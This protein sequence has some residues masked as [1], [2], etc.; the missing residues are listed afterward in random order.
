MAQ[1]KN[2]FEVDHKGMRELHSGRE[3]WQLIK[4][5]VSNSFD[6]VSATECHVTLTPHTDRTAELVVW[7][8]GKGFADIKDAW[9]L[10][11]HTPKRINP[12]VRGRFNI[13]EKELLCTAK[14][15]TITTSGHRIVF[16]DTG[17]RVYREYEDTHGTTIKA[18]LY[19]GS[20][21]IENAI[22]MLKRILPPK[23]GIY[24]I[25]GE[26]VS[27]KIPD[28]TIE[29]TLETVAWEDGVEK[30]P[31]RKTDIEFFKVQDGNGWLYEMGI[32]VQEI[33]CEYS[34]NVLQ[35][36]PMPPNR[37]VVKDKYLQDIYTLVL[38]TFSEEVTT[39]SASW[40]HTAMEDKEIA[41][42]AVKDI[43]V[44]RYGTDKVV[45]WSKDPRAN[46]E[47]R[48]HGYEVIH[49]RTL[50]GAEREVIQEYGGV[51]YSGNAFPS[52][53]KEVANIP[54]GEWTAEMKHTVYYTRFLHRLLLGKDINVNFYSDKQTI[55]TASYGSSIIN[56]NIAHCGEALLDKVSPELTALLLHEFSHN[57]EGGADSVHGSR[58]YAEFQR[59]SGLAVHFAATNTEFQKWLHEE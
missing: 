15:A 20:R 53:F 43:I 24:I 55:E 3:A 2:W 8:N 44:N 29:G 42:K 17:R 6:E 50:S 23:I 28:K 58:W 49:G 59:L 41:P 27:C 51:Q 16:S 39:P 38:N 14:E 56:F 30:H 32:P 31:K 5:L 37:D 48:L 35:K 9:T 47:A 36:I 19:L 45:L 40:V 22:I 34:V 10:M 11:A 46:D 52:S 1:K 25:N 33:E 13:G 12:T 57:V 54:A 7:D 18:I 21:Q 4:E 26:V